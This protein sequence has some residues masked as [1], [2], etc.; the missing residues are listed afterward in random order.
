M[1]SKLT[2]TS[3]QLYRKLLLN[4]VLRTNNQS[5]DRY[6]KY[7]ILI[8]FLSA[9]LFEAFHTDAQSLPTP[10]ISVLPYCSGF[11]SPT[12]IANCG[13]T[14][15]FV[16]EKNGYI[17]IIDANGNKLATPFLNI[18]AQV[19]SS[20]NEQGL[21][22]LCFH[23]N[24]TSNGYFYVYFTDNNGHSNLKRYTRNASN[25][26]IA[27]MAS[28]TLIFFQSQPAANHNG[29]CIQFGP[30]GYLYLGLGDG[31][32]QGDPNGNGQNKQTLLG[33]MIRID[34]NNGLPYT[35]PATN[36]FI[37]ISNVLGE[38][39]AIG[40]RNPWR[41]SFDRLTGD[42]W[43]GDVGEG[44]WEE[45][46]YQP[47][48]VGGRN[49]GWRC[50]EG[51]HSYNTSGC[52]G[53][54]TYTAPVSEYQH[55]STN[56]CSI[57][58]GYVYRGGKYGNLFGHYLATDYCS[59][60]ILDITP[61]GTG[62]WN[63]ISLGTFSPY[64]YSAFGEDKN[65][66]LYLAEL[67]SGQIMKIKENG[68]LPTAYIKGSST[69]T[70]CSGSSIKLES[71]FGKGNTYQWQRNNTP[72]QGATA[73]S[74]LPLASGNYKV[75]VSNSSGCSNTSNAISV[76]LSA[77]PA[78]SINPN[79]PTTFCQGSSVLLNANSGSGLSYKWKKNGTYITGATNS[80]Y[81]ASKTAT[82]KVEVNAANGC[83]TLS[84]GVS[85]L[86]NCRLAEPGKQDFSFYCNPNPST[87]KIRIHYS[88]ANET[89]VSVLITDLI[90]KKTLEYPLNIHD[91]EGAE[92]LNLSDLPKGIY[93]ITLFNQDF[94]KV[95]KIV[96]N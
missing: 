30:D 39:W 82:Y 89:L 31:G 66:E 92:E 22:G 65:G 77:S 38:I 81:I 43:I 96:L 17:Y 91:G 46:N 51:N 87:G 90:G 5:F 95:N 42:Q 50:Y 16:G 14:R 11:S 40:L 25:P 71:I 29:G 15:L 53:Q 21:L 57:T 4:R 12:V 80:G 3:Q 13:D 78:A 56:G 26:N 84:S 70:A 88:S 60:V 34:V 49:Y 36:P 28:E 27:N 33:K 35:I 1:K 59:G 62:G 67:G 85:V 7:L 18:D 55:S 9:L 64:Q 20:G 48:G 72:I 23:P 47:S 93:F 68:C 83:S 10:S 94:R 76:T 19:G 41:W 86:V 24:Y 73:S 32:N 54:N 2:L 69:I 8:I 79:G 74:Y 45:V 63:T 6:I 52:S 61:N 58:G 44:T 37:G 75:I